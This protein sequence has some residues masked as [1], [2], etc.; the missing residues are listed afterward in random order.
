MNLRSYNL[1]ASPVSG[2]HSFLAN[3]KLVLQLARR[4]VVGRYRGSF[5]GLAWSFFNPLLMLGVYTFVFSVIFEARWAGLPEGGKATFA[6]ILF[7]GLIMHG[8]LAE[9]VNRAP[10]LI[11]SNASYVKKVVF[12]L[13]MLPVITMGGALFHA[14]V[15]LIVLL[16]AKLLVD[17]QI[18]MT[19]ILFPLVVAPFA[20][21]VVGLAWVV[22]ALGVYIR[23]IGQFT[24]ILTTAMLFLSPIFYPLS[25]V[26]E[27]IRV[28][29]L[30]NPLT[31]VVGQTRAV[32]LGIGEINWAGLGVYTL[33]AVA[34]ASFGY[35]FF[36][37]MRA[38]FADVV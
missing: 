9:C 15:A 32:L 11:T 27:G 22:A 16:L 4:E 2:V 6:I 18:P 7:S 12:P 24:G 30:L 31:F 28:L 26:P 33:I 38:G 35:W 29:I 36:Q 5:L 21:L 8:L 1:S 34:I 3:R 10:S 14:G 23:D 17:G 25:A 13:D 19:V 37:R 20:V